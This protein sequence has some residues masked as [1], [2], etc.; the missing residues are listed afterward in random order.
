MLS[1]GRSFSSIFP[2]RRLLQ[3]FSFETFCP[4][5]RSPLTSERFRNSQNMFIDR[6]RI[7]RHAA[8]VVIR[9]HDDR[10]CSKN[11]QNNSFI[12]S[13]PYCQNCKRA[14]DAPH[15]VVAT[16]SFRQLKKAREEHCHPTAGTPMTVYRYAKTFFF[17]RRARNEVLTEGELP[18]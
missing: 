14:A 7:H 11:L 8:S 3:P 1:E 17:F 12:A 15:R 18:L 10:N 2:Y 4:H 5:A 6:D 9:I 16:G 13:A